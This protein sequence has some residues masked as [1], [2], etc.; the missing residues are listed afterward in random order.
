MK[1]LYDAFT[2]SVFLAGSCT[3]VVT[4]HHV[5]IEDEEGISLF[6]ITEEEL[7]ELLNKIQDKKEGK[8]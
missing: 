2:H 1:K 4:P 8:Q 7:K 6:R 3:V 5:E